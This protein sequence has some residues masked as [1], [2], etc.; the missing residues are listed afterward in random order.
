MKE[1]R[2]MKTI[3]T[4]LAVVAALAATMLT[5]LTRADAIHLPDLPAGS[6][7]Q[8]IFVTADTHDARSSDIGVYN[9]FVTQ[10]AAQAPSL[11]SATW[12]AVG[13]TSSVDARDNALAYQSIPIYD[14]EGNLVATGY[15]QLW[16][17]QLQAPVAYDQLGDFHSGRAVWTGT[18]PDGTKGATPNPL[19]T[20]N[21]YSGTTALGNVYWL[22][23]GTGS[24]CSGESMY[25][26]SSLIIVPSS[27][28]PEPGTLTLL[29][30]AL[31]GLAG[32][33]LR[34][35]RAGS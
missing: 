28:V 18:E 2:P 26:L 7:Y 25:G 14:L 22:T 12:W 17:G 27:P 9:I 13:S 15:D 34:R 35:R 29:G 6:K 10:Q 23:D 21:A 4:F 16:S 5:Q 3:H 11:P 33:T 32:V 1:P 24:T 19:G 31:L 20:A 30:S 8:L